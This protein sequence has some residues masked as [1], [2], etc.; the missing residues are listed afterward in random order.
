MKKA[1]L[2]IDTIENLW[3]NK[4]NYTVKKAIKKAE[5]SG[6]TVGQGVSKNNL[7]E[8][9][10]PLYLRA[11]KKFGTP[12]HSL[13]FF[14]NLEKS[15]KTILVWA[16]FE[17]KTIAVLLGWEENKNMIVGYNPSEP[18][19]WDLR[20]ND[21]LHWELIKESIKRG[22]QY[23]DFGPVRYEGQLQY[24]KKWGCDIYEDNEKRINPD[25]WFYRILRILWRTFVPLRWTPYL[26]KL[27]R[28]K[29]H[30]VRTITSFRSQKMR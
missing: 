18:K 5:R 10:Y 30:G 15:Q 14:F 25:L 21:L 20:A 17:G 22:C 9:F 23:V 11:M 16:D 6:L 8:K 4:L 13:E 19:Y 26:G 1:R 3:K 27:L 7:K 29:E 12:P 24:K 28:S 2:K